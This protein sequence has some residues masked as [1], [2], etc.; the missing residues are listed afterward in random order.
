M[1][2]FKIKI[3]TRN[4]V[5]QLWNLNEYEGLQQLI[6]TQ[7]FLPVYFSLLSIY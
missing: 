2:F 6:R 7:D 4:R 5:K 1:E 3:E